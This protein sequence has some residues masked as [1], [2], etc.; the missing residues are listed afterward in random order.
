MTTALQGGSLEMSRPETR[1]QKQD[2]GC[3]LPDV[4]VHKHLACGELPWRRKACRHASHAVSCC[5]ECE[6]LAGQNLL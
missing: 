5:A 6:K 3:S 1:L 2:M 4:H